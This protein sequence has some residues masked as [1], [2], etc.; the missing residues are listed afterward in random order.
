MSNFT[1]SNNSLAT[2]LTFF[3]HINRPLFY[4]HSPNIEFYSTTE[5]LNITYI[6]LHIFCYMILFWLLGF[7]SVVLYF[8]MTW[9]GCESASKNLKWIEK[10]TSRFYPIPISFMKGVFFCTTKFY[11][12]SS[13]SVRTSLNSLYNCDPFNFFLFKA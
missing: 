12:I 3:S 7:T 13:L 2:V 1:S 6:G 4:T 9:S 11:F 8:C 10:K 5:Y